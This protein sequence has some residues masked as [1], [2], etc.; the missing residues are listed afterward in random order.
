MIKNVIFDYG[1][2]LVRFY[3][4]EIIR[5][6]GVAESGNAALL[7]RVLF[8]RVYWDRLDD[9]S[10]SQED[11]K[12]Q[13]R[14]NLP[15]ELHSLSDKICD[16]W[17]TALPPVEGM[18]E[19][20]Q[21]LKSNGCKLYILSN[22][23]EHFAKNYKKIPLFDIFDGLVFSGEIK[24]AKP[25]IRIFEHILN[26]YSLSANECV[27]VDDNE[28]NISAAKQCNINAYLFD[29]AKNAEEFILSL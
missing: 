19:L 18:H 28:K 1:N 8:D 4:D 24:L 17:I 21:K 5:S 7:E 15:F 13:V 23:S 16:E 27:F 9:G 12:S 14:K 3:P 20:A 26:K 11:F 25:D 22:I 10:L 6:F 2:T 29:N